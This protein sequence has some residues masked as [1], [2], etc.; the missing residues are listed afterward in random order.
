MNRREEHSR[1]HATDAGQS[2]VKFRA[3]PSR[4]M[5]S[6]LG[7]VFCTRSPAQQLAF[8]FERRRVPGFEVV[9]AFGNRTARE[10]N[11]SLQLMLGSS[12]KYQIFI[13]FF[14]RKK[15]RTAGKSCALAA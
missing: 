8:A 10:T 15:G 2:V 9:D 12:I 5:T 14:N 3:V 1:G 6:S 11:V 4:A 7:E 13:L